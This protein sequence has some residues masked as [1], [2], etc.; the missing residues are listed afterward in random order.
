VDYPE[1]KGPTI[2]MISSPDNPY[3]KLLLILGRD[4]QDLLTAVQGLGRGDVMLRG[5]SVMV[6]EVK[7]L[8]PR[9]PYD[10]PNWVRL[11]RKM[12]FDEL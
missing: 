4:Q 5:Q 12:R 9:Q 1:V 3:V 11:D 6:D 10:A 2:D 7:P 8:S